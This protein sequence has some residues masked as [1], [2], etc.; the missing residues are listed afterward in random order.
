MKKVIKLIQ[1]TLFWIMSGLSLSY[2]AS[3]ILPNWAERTWRVS[4]SFSGLEYQ[5][6]ECAKRILGICTSHKMV[7]EYKDFKDSDV[8]KEFIAAGIV[9]RKD[10]E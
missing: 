9:C 3:V 5:H 4:P 1:M 7:I 8:R 10:K 6:K 2:C